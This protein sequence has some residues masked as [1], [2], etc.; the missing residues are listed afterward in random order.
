MEGLFRKVD[1]LQ[2]SGLHPATEEA[3]HMLAELPKYDDVLVTVKTGRSVKNHR[4][5]FSFF[6]MTF[7]WQDEYEN[8]DIW[9]RV[10]TLKAGH[11]LTVVDKKGNTQFWPLS[12]SFGE[13]DDEHKFKKLFNEIVRVYLKDFGGNLSQDQ[14]NQANS[15]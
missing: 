14:I 6:K 3:Q 1:Y 9:R 5:L 13:L 15:Y 10:L 12:I 4:R 2:G 7:D 11:F 8:F